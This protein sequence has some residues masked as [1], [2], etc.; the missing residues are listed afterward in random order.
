MKNQKIIGYYTGYGMDVKILNIEY[1]IDDKMKLLLNGK[2]HL[3]RVVRYDEQKECEPYI[4]LYK[5]RLYLSDFLRIGSD[6]A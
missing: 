5:E 2:K 3:T 1:G 4:E 6:W